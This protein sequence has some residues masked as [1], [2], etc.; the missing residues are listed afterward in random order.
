[1]GV[2]TVAE[3]VE[4]AE[5]LTALALIGVDFAQGNWVRRAVPL[6]QIHTVVGSLD[7]SGLQRTLQVPLVSAR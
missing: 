5:V 2:R 1:M 4:S 7:D 3:G 6:V